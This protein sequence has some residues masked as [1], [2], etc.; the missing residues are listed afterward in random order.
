M[1]GAVGIG[2]ASGTNCGSIATQSAALSSLL[3]VC[4]I[5]EAEK[6]LVRVAKGSGNPDPDVVEN[7]RYY[8]RAMMNPK[9]MLFINSTTDEALL[10]GMS[11]TIVSLRSGPVNWI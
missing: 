5:Q 10:K 2:Q 4:P 11:V 9:A 3:S 7:V 8:V 1:I 6:V